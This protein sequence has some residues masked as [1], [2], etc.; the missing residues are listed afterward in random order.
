MNMRSHLLNWLYDGAIFVL[1]A[2][3]FLL[4]PL[5]IVVYDDAYVYFTYARN[6]VEG[7]PFA[8]D[9]RNIPS[10]G[11][12]SLLYML[13]LVPA[14]LLCI[15]P[16]LAGALINMTA[17]A[18]AVVVLGQAMRATGI[19]SGR[20]AAFFTLLLAILLMRDQN[21]RQLVFSGFEA[22]LGVL[23]AA[24]IVISTAY[25]LDERR[26]AAARRRWLSVFFVA[27]FLAH[28]VRPEYLLIGALSGAVLLWRSPERAALLRRTAIFALVMASYYLLKLAIFGDLLPTGFYRKVRASQDGATYVAEWLQRYADVFIASGVAFIVSLVFAPRRQAQWIALL[29]AGA[30]SILLFYTQTTPLAGIFDRFLIVPIW[31]LYAILA[32][33]IVMSIAQLS[34]RLGV[35][36]RAERLV[37]QRWIA[38][39]LTAAALGAL[40][41]IAMSSDL[42]LLAQGAQA[43]GLFGLA[44][45]AH[46]A[47]NGNPYIQLGR[48]WREQLGDPTTIT[49]AH[50]DAGAIPYALGSRFLDLQGL[51]EPPIAHMFGRLNAPEQIQ[52][53]IQY[54]LS[55][56][57]DVLLLWAIHMPSLESTWHSYHD[58][59]SPFLDRLPSA[60]FEAYQ[61]YGLA[62]GCSIELSWLRLHL[63][64]QR[65]DETHFERLMNAFCS[66]PSARRFPEGLTVVASDG[67]IHFP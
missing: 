56:S 28:L 59:H 57:P 52:S 61:A 12:T 54:I 37:K 18:L 33:G 55:K 62:Y 39:L 48:Y 21:I 20:A 10:E 5:Q 67:Q 17:L 36:Q 2:A 4:A 49:L 26:S 43:Q 30:I 11:F 25:A 23:C 42:V 29:A 60:L 47:M 8:Y 50:V 13:M 15:N 14:E 34:R 51:T 7:R 45:R 35:A 3:F 6:F 31:T 46:D 24:G 53:Y 64:V 27:S 41:V 19:L 1:I 22:L 9:P 16:I 66:H 63:L 40:L 38:R 58:L 65:A 44:R 32:L